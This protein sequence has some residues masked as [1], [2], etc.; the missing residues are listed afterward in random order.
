MTPPFTNASHIIYIYARNIADVDELTR[1]V[2]AATL[3]GLS[4]VGLVGMLLE[5]P[6]LLD[7][8]ALKYTFATSR[9]CM[10]ITFPAMSILPFRV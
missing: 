9:T 10:P 8:P 6:I 5:V 2:D 3:L 4:F 7:I 1:D